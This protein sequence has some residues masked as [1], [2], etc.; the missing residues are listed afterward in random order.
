VTPSTPIAAAAQVMRD[1]AASLLTVVD[2]PTTARIQGLISDR[3]ILERCVSARH[4][5]GCLVRDH[6]TAHPLVTVAPDDALDDVVQRMESARVHRV[7][8]VESSGR[9]VGIIARTSLV[10]PS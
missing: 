8:V 10:P 9:V 2:D 4:G 1:S 6:M 7:P 3:D 5:P